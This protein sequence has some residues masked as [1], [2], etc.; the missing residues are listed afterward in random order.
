MV[1]TRDPLLIAGIRGVQR[2]R[3]L[4]AGF[5]TIDAVAEALPAI[6]AGERSVD[7]IAQP[8]L[9]RLA[10]QAS[11]QVDAHS[12]GQAGGPP[13]YRVVDPAALAAIPRPNP[14]DLF[15]DFEGD[16]LYRCLL[17]TSRCV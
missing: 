17:Y 3:L 10:L 11:V 13:P 14:G 5:D 15:F 9:E 7:A 8:A 6:S 16:P 4:D 12:G 2:D 1:R